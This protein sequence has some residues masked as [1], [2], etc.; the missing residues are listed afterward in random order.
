MH[1]LRY[2]GTYRLSLF[3]ELTQGVDVNHPRARGAGIVPVVALGVVTSLIEL[4]INNILENQRPLFPGYFKLCAS[5]YLL[6]SVLTEI[7]G[8]QE[9]HNHRSWLWA[10][11]TSKPVRNIMFV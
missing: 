9:I 10:S 6:F 1:H 4:C 11:A 8:L 7:F 5:F 2:D 3:M